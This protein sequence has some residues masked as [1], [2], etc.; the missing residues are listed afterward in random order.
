MDR[1]EGIH[2]LDGGAQAHATS[3]QAIDTTLK[4]ATEL[5]AAANLR[6]LLLVALRSAADLIEFEQVLVRLQSN[7]LAR[8]SHVKQL[9]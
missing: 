2:T 6:Q 5:G 3:T 4:M 9:T 7:V 8:S 1:N